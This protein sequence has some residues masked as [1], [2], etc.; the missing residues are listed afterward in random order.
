MNVYIFTLGCKVNQYESQEIGEM[1]EKSGYTL[2]NEPDNADIIIVNSCT[3]TAESVRKVRQSVRHLKKISPNAFLI[4]TGCAS[5]AEP[6]ILS[7][8]PEVNL[9]LGNRNNKNIVALCENALKEHGSS[10]NAHEEHETG[11]SFQ[12][13]GITHF[14]GHTRAFLKIQDGCD[15]FCSYCLIPKARGRSRSKPLA[16]IDRE[17]SEL[18]KNGYGEIVFVGINLS[19]YG[20]NT[21]Y[22]LPDALMLAE[23]YDSIKRVRLGSL[24]PDHITDEM[25]ERLKNV[26]KLCPQFHISLQSGCN[27]VLKRMNRH[28]TREEYK[29]LADSLR[30]A[31]KDAS[32]TTDILVGFPTESE[33]DFCETVDFAKSIGFEKIHIFPYSKR[34]GT[35]AAAMPQL[36]NA[37]KDERAKRLGA[38]AAEIRKEYLLKQVGKTCEVLFETEHPE[39]SEGYTKNYTPVRIYDG[40][41]RKGKFLN[42]LITDAGDD[43]CIGIEAT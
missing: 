8:L 17:L 33:A 42:I 27:S 30:S 2:L 41:D 20:K 34:N 43:Y 25:I 39:F 4:L 1:F 37:I 26:T 9:M 5:Q 18:S 36:S 11:E 16:D 28:Y 31:F 38:A 40:K 35:P 23:K 3:V 19:D 10:V 32:V 22:S 29:A 24:E 14:E 21:P 6:E 12:G 7:V 13:L 15:R